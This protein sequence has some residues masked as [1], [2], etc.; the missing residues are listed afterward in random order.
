LSS[1]Y[2]WFLAIGK[3]LGAPNE[4]PAIEETGDGNLC[5]PGEE[6]E[7]N[8]RDELPILFSSKDGSNSST[9]IFPLPLAEGL[10]GL[11][12]WMFDWGEGNVISKGLVAPPSMANALEVSSSKGNKCKPDLELGDSCAGDV[13][14]SRSSRSML[15][16]SMVVKRI[17]NTSKVRNTVSG[18]PKDQSVVVVEDDSKRE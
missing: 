12:V 6:E 15:K 7:E 18:A 1:W 13:K 2:P 11:S 8:D 3:E 5:D 10:T 17:R 14:G 16:A 9:V 4:V